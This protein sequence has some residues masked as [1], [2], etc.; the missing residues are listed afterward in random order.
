MRHHRLRPFEL[1]QE[2]PISSIADL[3]GRAADAAAERVRALSLVPETAPQTAPSPSRLAQVEAAFGVFDDYLESAA[4]IAA[5]SDRARTLWDAGG[6]SVEAETSAAL[7]FAAEA[8]T[9]VL[10]Q[11]AWPTEVVTET[12]APVPLILDVPRDTVSLELFVRAASSPRLLDL[13]PLLTVE[14]QLRLLLALSPITEVSL[15]ADET[16]RQLR[17]V[18]HAGE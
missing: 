17:C 9:G 4:A 15:W 16:D 7:A 13:P 10:L 12:V 6:D 14:L 11:R 2:A 3:S 5:A 18:S 1:F 8:L